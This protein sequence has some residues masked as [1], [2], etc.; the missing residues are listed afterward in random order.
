MNTISTTVMRAFLSKSLKPNKLNGLLAEVDFR[1]HLEELGYRDRVS[2]G[3]WV[4]RS[5][6]VNSFAEQA[7]ALFPDVIDPSGDYSPSR[8]EPNPPLGL[9]SISAVFHSIGIPSFHCIPVV[10]RPNDVRALYWQARQLGLPTTQPL[11]DL[12]GIVSDGFEIRERRHNFLTSSVD[13]S[14]IP[15]AA[16]PEEFSKEHLRITFQNAFKAEVSDIDGVFWGRQYT[17][18]LEIKE[19]TVAHDNS[20]G[21]Y[22]GLDVGPFVKLAFFA[23]K[24]GNLHSIFVVRE[25]TDRISRRLAGWWFIT[26]EEIARYASWTPIGGGTGMTG[27]R[28]AVIRIAKSRFHRL[29]AESLAQL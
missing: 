1:R 16:I 9:H 7:V 11:S 21:D 25:I 19:K 22:F 14:A 3:G 10:S 28:S 5:T 20:S 12:L 26:F 6:G 29:D 24:G 8:P 27:G 18:P 15:D 2:V 4:V 23:A 17:Y 13:V